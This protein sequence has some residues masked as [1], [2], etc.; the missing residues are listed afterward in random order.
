MRSDDHVPDGDG[1]LLYIL[2]V[3]FK[4]A[5]FWMVLKT[6]MTETRSCHLGNSPGDC[7]STSKIIRRDQV[8]QTVSVHSRKTCHRAIAIAMVN[9][10]EVRPTAT[11]CL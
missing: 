5:K 9:E 1:T 6:A 3:S 2:R 8:R 10:R 11:W 4:V 7:G